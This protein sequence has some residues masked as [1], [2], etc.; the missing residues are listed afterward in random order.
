[1]KY[2]HLSIYI[3][4]IFTSIY[5]LC[6][7]F[8]GSF[9]LELFRWPW[10]NVLFFATPPGSPLWRKRF[11]SIQASLMLLNLQRC[12][13]V[14][15]LAIRPSEGAQWLTGMAAISGF[16]WFVR[17]APGVGP[18]FLNPVDLEL[19]QRL[20]GWGGRRGGRGRL[21]GW[22]VLGPPLAHLCV[23]ELSYPLVRE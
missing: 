13:S 14:S 8:I 9:C 12:T 3:Y 16:L 22:R 21:C 23:A 1:M 5:S 18:R 2:I 4:Y 15:D 7:C 19:L 10:G 11:A 17:G 20:G 6:S